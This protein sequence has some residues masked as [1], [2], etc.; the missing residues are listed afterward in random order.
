MSAPA[1]LCATAGIRTQ[2]IDGDI[3]RLARKMAKVATPSIK[4]LAELRRLKA[5]KVELKRLLTAH[6]AE[7]GL[8]VAG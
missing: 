1:C 3:F 7:C 2:D 5:A 8:A 4:Q 6:Y